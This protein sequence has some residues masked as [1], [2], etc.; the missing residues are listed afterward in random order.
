LLFSHQKRERKKSKQR[1]SEDLKIREMLQA[2]KLE[3]GKIS[4]PA[5]LC[6]SCLT[7]H[8]KKRNEKFMICLFGFQTLVSNFGGGWG[9][10][11]QWNEVYWRL[12]LVT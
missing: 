8:N 1:A 2:K 7:R 10:G 3:S 6:A 5:F 9:L 4:E 12:V 11:L